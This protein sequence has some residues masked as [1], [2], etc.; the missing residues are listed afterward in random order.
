MGIIIQIEL[1]CPSFLFL[2]LLG[3]CMCLQISNKPDLTTLCLLLMEMSSSDIHIHP[4]RVA[5]YSV[6]TN[7]YIDLHFRPQ[8]EVTA[9]DDN[10]SAGNKL[11]RLKMDPREYE[12]SWGEGGKMMPASHSS[13]C[14][15][16][17][18]MKFRLH[19]NKLFS[20]GT[21]SCFCEEMSLRISKD[22]T[23][24]IRI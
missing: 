18:R 2:F 20:C 8:P 14:S 11:R 15:V 12:W 17:D 21:P 24:F 10:I 4:C 16:Y 3:G 6:H 9:G 5:L 7:E 22:E 1:N 23:H 19:Q 13:V